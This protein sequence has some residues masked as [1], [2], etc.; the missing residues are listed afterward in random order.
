MDFVTTMLILSRNNR[1]TMLFSVLSNDE[2]GHLNIYPLA[3]S[4][5]R[6]MIL[7]ASSLSPNQSGVDHN[8]LSYRKLN[9]CLMV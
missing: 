6:N 4:L 8:G 9:T 2:Q 7:V 5:L 1:L 3:T